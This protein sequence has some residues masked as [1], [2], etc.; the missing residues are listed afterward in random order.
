MS[1]TGLWS[2][3]SQVWHLHI[4]EASSS[5]QQALVSCFLSAC[6]AEE[7]G[8]GRVASLCSFAWSL[9]AGTDIMLRGVFFS[10]GTGGSCH[11]R[12]SQH[13]GWVTAELLQPMPEWGWEAQR[14]G[15][16]GPV[17]PA[18]QVSGPTVKL[19]ICLSVPSASEA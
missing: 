19:G 12:N 15:S 7:E 18:Q 8:Q 16:E 14:Q 10:V 17:H 5:Q 6:L 13:L 4:L 1:R 2:S 9:A 3:L 11:S